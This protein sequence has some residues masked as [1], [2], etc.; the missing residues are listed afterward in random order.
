MYKIVLLLLCFLSVGCASRP[1]AVP[2]Q[3]QYVLPWGAISYSGLGRDQQDDLKESLK[4]ALKIQLDQGRN[5]I[6]MLA[7]SG[8]SQ[9]GAFGAGILKGWEEDG[10]RPDFTVVT[11]IS[12]GALISVFAFL[13]PEHDKTLQEL[14]TETDETNIYAKRGFFDRFVQ[15]SIFSTAPL[16]H[17]IETHVT[18]ALIAEVAAEYKKGRRLY[19]GSTDLD[20]RTLTVWDMGLIA[21]STHPDK[22]HR[23]RKALLAS[24]SMPVLFPPVYFDVLYGGRTYYQMHVDGG[25]SSPVFFRGILLDYDRARAD[26]TEEG[27]DFG[28]IT[29]NVN[30]IVNDKL[31]LTPEAKAV[32]PDILAIA[33]ASFDKNYSS[34]SNNSLEVIA[35]YAVGADL[36]FR[37]TA[38]PKE[39]PEPENSLDINK[40]YMLDLYEQAR[41]GA[42]DE[43]LWSFSILDQKFVERRKAELRN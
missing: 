2:D 37:M 30:I 24:S 15:D 10:G 4:A 11:G 12:T 25:V 41:L 17:L 26:L 38:I 16:W 21:N 14:Y 22:N 8:G 18:D 19:V 27:Y 28:Q 34:F 40:D 13:G 23:F 5:Q 42:A 20:N 39:W 36:G 31:R 7:L 33:A 6:D 3:S 9:K 35:A 43:S 1:E 29:E 32:A